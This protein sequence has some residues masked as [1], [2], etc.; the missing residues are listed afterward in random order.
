MDQFIKAGLY[1]A[2]FSNAFV[3]ERDEKG[4][5]GIPNFPKNWNTKALETRNKTGGLLGG[6][7]TGESCGIIAIDCD[8]SATY[9]LF[10]DLDPDYKF[11]FVSLGKKDKATNEVMDCGTIIYKYDSSLSES[12]QN[13]SNGMELDFMSNTGHRMVYLPTENNKT[14]VEWPVGELPEIKEVP[15]TVKMVLISLGVKPVAAVAVSDSVSKADAEYPALAPALEELVKSGKCNTKLATTFTTKDFKGLPECNG[16]PYLQPKDVPEG[17]GNDYL[18]SVSAIIGADP[19]VS[20]PLYRESMNAV[21]GLWGTKAFSKKRLNVMIDRMIAGNAAWDD[22]VPIWRYNPEWNKKDYM[23]L[24]KNG[25]IVE[26]FYDNVKQAHYLIDYTEG[27]EHKHAKATQLVDELGDIAKVPSTRTDYRAKMQT[28]ST[29]MN[30]GME[31]GHVEGTNKFNLFKQTPE[32]RILKHPEEWAANYVRPTTTL[33]FME[34]LVPEDE[35]RE[36]L[37]RF[38]KTKLTNFEYS[39]VILY[40]LGVRGSGKNIFVNILKGIIGKKYISKP[41]VDGFVDKFNNWLI[42]RY[43]TQ[44]DEIGDLLRGPK[45][46]TVEGLL[47][48]FS[49]DTD[50]TVTL[51]GVDSFDY[52]HNITFILTANTNPLQIQV[53]D[54]RV[55]Y[56]K[57]ENQLDQQEWIGEGNMTKAH[58]QIMGEIKNFCYY[59]ATEVDLLKPDEYRKAPNT[60]AKKELAF[61]S[62]NIIHLLEDLITRG[63]WEELANLGKRY[64]IAGFTNRWDKNSIVRSTLDRLLEKMDNKDFYD[65][66]SISNLFDKLGYEPRRTKLKGANAYVYDIKRSLNLSKYREKAETGF[67]PSIETGFVGKV[68]ISL[69]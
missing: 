18:K 59:L 66:Y 48:D 52:K 37:L 22:G 8:N 16:K 12:F 6:L 29:V 15:D 63:D 67:E 38:M 3:M 2:V 61:E 19:S 43:F 21:N 57:T 11:H 23:P 50:C 10:K 45:S 49:G 53:K 9:K 26:A 46:A 42:D 35:M 54:R 14:K 4:A 7:M 47:K 62:M 60:K 65:D 36:Y 17:M 33:K 51:K 41:S 5:K 58:D 1:T 30:P 25:N 56:I 31:F 24:T 44:L 69:D 55:A 39:P 64:E 68:D 34:S 20:K 27:F 40:F 28:L 13:K 32:L